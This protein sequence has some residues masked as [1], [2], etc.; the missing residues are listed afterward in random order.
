MNDHRRTLEERLKRQQKA[1]QEDGPAAEVFWRARIAETERR[2]RLL[3]WRP[4]PPLAI[5]P[6]RPPETTN[7]S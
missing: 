5:P 1:L 7:G 4:G 6:G 3:G 2:L